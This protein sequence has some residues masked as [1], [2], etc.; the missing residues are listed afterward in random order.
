[1]N[2][3]SVRTTL[4]LSTFAACGGGG[5][6]ADEAPPAEE[7]P[8]V[9]QPAAETNAAVTQ[10]PGAGAADSSDLETLTGQILITG[11]A[12]MEFVT[13]QIDGG[14]AGNL[15]GELSSELGRLSG[16]MVSVE[17]SRTAA[18]PLE[19]F[20][21]TAYEVMSIDGQQ[22]SVGILQERDGAFTI[23]GAE[24]V[25]L[26]G[27]PGRAPGPG[28][29]QGVGGRAPNRLR[30]YRYR[31]TGSFESRKALP[32][33][34]TPPRPRLAAGASPHPERVRRGDRRPIVPALR[35]DACGDPTDRLGS[36]RSP[37]R[38]LGHYRQAVRQPTINAAQCD[39]A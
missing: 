12:Q 6:V 19:G 22:P 17:G 30:D 27:V 20:E 31:A 4:L 38:R 5:D 16:A 32:Q 23:A 21:A 10:E 2:F 28:G 1:M 7:T 8:S 24:T 3:S 25:G 15:S 29:G 36:A 9:G 13:L 14:G 35:R 11:T 26:T 34:G 37:T 39:T 18:T 33:R